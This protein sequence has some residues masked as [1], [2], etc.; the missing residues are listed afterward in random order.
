MLARFQATLSLNAFLTSRNLLLGGILARISKNNFGNPE[1]SKIQTCLRVFGNP[2]TSKIHMKA[3]RDAC[4]VWHDSELI[5]T[6]FC[7][8]IC[9]KWD[10]MFESNLVTSVDR[11]SFDFWF[12]VFFGIC[13]SK[14]SHS[15]AVL[16]S[17]NTDQSS[18]T[19][20]WRFVLNS[21]SQFS[22]FQGQWAALWTLSKICVKWKYF[23]P[24]LCR[25]QWDVSIKGLSSRFL[26]YHV[27]LW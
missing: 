9:R 14:E 27:W 19:W 21:S 11:T 4:D 25:I 3:R 8:Q 2:E 5:A 22:L 13:L 20:S 6:K 12:Q 7:R 18:I 1:T 17:R 26:V 16:L 10:A 24:N 23:N 15:S